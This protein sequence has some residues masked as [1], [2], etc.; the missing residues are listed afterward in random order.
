MKKLIWSLHF[1]THTECWPIVVQRIPHFPPIL[2]SCP[3]YCMRYPTS[4]PATVFVKVPCASQV[5]ATSSLFRI[6]R[7]AGT[8]TTGLQSLFSVASLRRAQYC[9][10]IL[11]ATEATNS[12][13][14]RAAILISYLLMFPHLLPRVHLNLPPRLASF[15]SYRSAARPPLLFPL[16]TLLVIVHKGVRPKT[17]QNTDKCKTWTG[18]NIKSKCQH[19]TEYI[20][21][22]L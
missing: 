19:H 13:V 18:L 14:Q 4:P 15:S 5:S 1:W 12:D 7:S 22:R 11:A 6:I 9:I 17:D 3:S 10:H 21:N 20:I 2:V 8:S 16:P